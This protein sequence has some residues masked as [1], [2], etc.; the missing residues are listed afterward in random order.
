MT[1]S[2]PAEPR[3]AA[4]PTALEWLRNELARSRAGTLR[5]LQVPAPAA[6][7]ETLLELR[8]GV[9]DAVLWVPPAA[10][11]AL[12]LSGLGSAAVLR[13]VGRNRFADVQSAAEQLWARVE[14]RHLVDGPPARCFGGFAFQPER[15]SNPPWDQLGDALAILPALRFARRGQQGWLSLAVDGEL[16]EVRQAELLDRVE[17]ALTLLQRAA[18]C[19]RLESPP[20]SRALTPSQVR[21]LPRDVWRDQ[22]EAIRGAIEQGETEKIVLA[23]RSDFELP[24]GLDLAVVLARLRRDARR[25]TRFVFAHRETLFLGATPERLLLKKGAAVVT[26]ALAGTFRAGSDAELLASKKD[27][28]EQSIVVQ[29]VARCLEPWCSELRYPAQPEVRAL[30][31]VV[32][33]H[34]PF[35]GTLNRPVHV[36]QLA[37]ELHPT[38]AVGG[39]PRARALEWIAA[40]EPTERGWY[41]GPVGWFDAA[42]DGELHV[43]LRS[44]VLRDRTAHLFAGA[45]IVRD[46]Q[47]DSEYDETRLK[48]AALASALEIEG[49][50]R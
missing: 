26:E 47:P 7:P 15:S 12:E 13:G 6:P 40:H 10:P 2:L 46:S 9:E 38:P 4:S 5:V 24:A 22:V 35:A 42:G 39:V 31:H 49:S 44:G 16:S 50:V 25:C 41:A 37:D 45:G 23:R 14:E 20:Q 28:S 29:E 30:K 43:A 27:L 36:L 18:G 34:T 21:E 33:L 48:L 19:S 8:D 1:L 3:P 11:D 32:H 17:R